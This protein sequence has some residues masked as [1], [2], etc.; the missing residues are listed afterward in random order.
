M[1]AKSC[2]GTAAFHGPAGEGPPGL[3][4]ATG[5]A[6]RSVVQPDEGDDG[7]VPVAEVSAP[8]LIAVC[9]RW[10]DGGRASEMRTGLVWPSKVI[11]TA[12][13]IILGWGRHFGLAR[14][15]CNHLPREDVIRCRLADFLLHQ[16]L[17]AVDW[18]NEA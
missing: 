6:R 12:V 1:G 8:G 9:G 11:Q 18:Y 13:A 14:I 10:R 2:D 16:Y 4:A 3:Y 5:I 7:V 17:L 15:Q